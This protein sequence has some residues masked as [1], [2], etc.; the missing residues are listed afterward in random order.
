MPEND[1]ALLRQFVDGDREAF[2]TLYRRHHREVHGWILRIVRDHASADDALVETFWRAFRSRA[3]FDAERPFG[4][5]I[6]RIATNAALNQL[7]AMSRRPVQ[8]DDGHDVAA[9]ARPDGE[10]RRQIAMALRSLSPKLRVVATLGLIEERPLAEIADALD[11]P[12]GTVK[13][14]LFRATRALRGELQR[15]GIQP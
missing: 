4:A 14:R 3:R 8:Y 13:S 6:R 15:K 2:E 10:V 1:V 11:V 12:V 5:W 7:R 9:P